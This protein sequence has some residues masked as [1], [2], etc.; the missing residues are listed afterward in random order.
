MSTRFDGFS[1]PEM[2]AIVAGLC[3]YE[4]S[5]A[6]QSNYCPSHGAAPSRDALI[7]EAM[8]ATNYNAGNYPDL[9]CLDLGADFT[10]Q[11]G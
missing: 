2:M 10:Q 9:I 1:G 7:Y 5:Q 11:G 8:Q 4:A 6:F 3:T